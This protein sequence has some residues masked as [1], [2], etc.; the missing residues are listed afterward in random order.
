[1]RLCKWSDPQQKH[2]FG[3]S[4]FPLAS[5]QVVPLYSCWDMEGPARATHCGQP[6]NTGLWSVQHREET[7]TLSPLA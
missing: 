5:Q 1:M 6:Q 2:T 7:S 3:L 4:Y